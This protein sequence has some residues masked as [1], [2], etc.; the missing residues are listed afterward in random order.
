MVSPKLTSGGDVVVVVV[1][2]WELELTLGMRR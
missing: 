1:R 2:I